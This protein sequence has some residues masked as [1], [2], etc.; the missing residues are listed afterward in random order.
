M[1][2]S[3]RIGT[4]LDRDHNTDIL[5]YIHQNPGCIKSAIYRNVT[6]NAHIRERMDEM[7]AMGL[8]ETLESDKVTYLWLTPKGDRIAEILLEADEVLNSGNGSD[9]ER[10]S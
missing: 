4:F 6:R 7:I 1:G 3:T 2:F 5:I 10:P 9:D 8:L